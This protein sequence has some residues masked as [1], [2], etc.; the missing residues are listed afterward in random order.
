MPP[1]NIPTLFMMEAEAFTAY[2]SIFVDIRRVSGG[3]TAVFLQQFDLT[4]P[5]K[6]DKLRK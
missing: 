1:L 2:L 4:T 5:V 6:N 3:E